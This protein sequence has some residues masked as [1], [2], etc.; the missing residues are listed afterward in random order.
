MLQSVATL[1]SLAD[2]NSNLHTR[3]CYVGHPEFAGWQ[4]VGL[5]DPPCVLLSLGG[6]S[7]HTP[8]GWSKEPVAEI[9]RAISVFF[10]L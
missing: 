9:C 1:C 5:T 2:S 3:L 7:Q 4:V 8:A 10:T 6:V